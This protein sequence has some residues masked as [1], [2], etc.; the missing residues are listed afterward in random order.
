MDRERRK[1]LVT[2]AEKAVKDENVTVW[3]RGPY[4]HVKV[5]FYWEQ[6]TR[7]CQYIRST[8]IEG[9]GFSKCRPGDCWSGQEG[10]NKARPRAIL[11]AVMQMNLMEV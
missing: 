10:I 7:D 5:A 1:R 11:D 8:Y 6:L 2:L 3:Q 9:H 4:T